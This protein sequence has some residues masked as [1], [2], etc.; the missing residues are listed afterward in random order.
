MVLLRCPSRHQAIQAQLEQEKAR[1]L[2]AE[3]DAKEAA[4]RK[5]RLVFGMYAAGTIGAVSV[6][7]LASYQAYKFVR[8][9]L[10]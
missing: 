2:I 7:G 3:K 1:R 6:V 5:D 9:V 4:R 10:E 8:R